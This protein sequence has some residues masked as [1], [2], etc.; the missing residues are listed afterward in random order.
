M[1]T[2][3]ERGRYPFGERPSGFGWVPAL[4]VIGE[5]AFRGNYARA[6]GIAPAKLV[7]DLT[8]C[9]LQNI[10]GNA[11]EH[12][13]DNESSVTLGGSFPGL[14]ALG[15]DLF[16]KFNGTVHWEIA[17]PALAIIQGNTFK[18]TRVGIRSE[19]RAGHLGISV[20]AEC[21]IQVSDENLTWKQVCVSVCLFVRASVRPSV[22]PCICLCV[23]VRL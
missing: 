5:D 9:P 14:D 18:D 19:E 4:K 16:N 22:R 2:V 11:W 17:A 6:E 13:G 1:G 7:L 8:G 15:S 12:A 10:G 3:S 20:P 21:G 23:C